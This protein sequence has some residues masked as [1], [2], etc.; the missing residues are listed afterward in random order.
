MAEYDDIMKGLLPGNIRE[1]VIDSLQRKA[2]IETN[3]QIKE[4]ENILDISGALA[5]NK[6]GSNKS[7]PFSSNISNYNWEGGPLSQLVDTSGQR[8]NDLGDIFNYII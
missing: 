5:N 4:I 2:D 3:L 8:F 6:P 7:A 1:E